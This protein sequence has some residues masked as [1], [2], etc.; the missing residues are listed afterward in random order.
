MFRI[1]LLLNLCAAS[2]HAG[3]FTIEGAVVRAA[4][5]N[6][7]LAAARW[8]IEQARGRLLQSG[9]PENPSLEA[10]LKPNVRGRE[11]SLSLGFTQKYPRTHRLYLER[12]VSQAE[13]TAAE[14]EVRNAE[15]L[16]RAEVRIA[17]VKLLAVQ[18]RRALKEQQ[19]KNSAELAADADRVAKAGEGSA[20]DASRFEL[21]VQRLSLDLLTADSESTVLIGTLR[22]LLGMSTAESLTISGELP[23]PSTAE[24]QTRPQQRAD[25][26]A[27]TAKENAAR[28]DVEVARAS[29]RADASYG[30]YYEREQADDAGAGLRKDDFIGFKFSL[31]LPFWHRNEGKIYEAEATAAKAHDERAALALRI[32]SEAAAAQAEMTAAAKIIAQTSGPLLTK[33]KEIEASH[34]AA[35]KL[36]QSPLADVL[37]ARELRFDLEEARLTAL[38]DYHLARARLL[39]AQGR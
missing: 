27:A 5:A 19:R 6:P 21:Q 11:F 37:R 31:P 26:Q 22:P 23:A 28:A 14:A 9:R 8:S 34:E 7:D 12:A 16:L 2:L 30:L 13:L 10:E 20:L 38:R 35:N 15:R 32:Q 36:G 3:T 1:L 18:A 29:T 4:R 25:Y 39:A 24:N 17:A 33:A